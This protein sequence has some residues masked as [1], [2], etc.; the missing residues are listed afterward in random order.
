MPE[1]MDVDKVLDGLNRA[2]CLQAQSVVRMSLLAGSM[3]GLG[4]LGARVQLRDFVLAETQ[5]LVQLAE[6][7]SAL[8][9]RP[10]A[11][12]GRIQVDSDPGTALP[13]LL[14]HEQ[15]AVAAMHA[16][17]P[18]TGEEA[19]SE[20]LEHLLEHLIMRKQQQV[21]LLW[22]AADLEEPLEPVDTD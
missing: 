16:V 9:G 1:P 13:A 20:A 14:Q 19:R 11:D 21:D 15:E 3:R 5:G 12:V 2:I 22:H 18:A 4:A 10:I 17:I 6:K 7:V 8:G